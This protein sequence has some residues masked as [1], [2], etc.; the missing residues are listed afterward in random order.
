MSEVVL[1]RATLE[2][3]PGQ[4]A[5]MK[6]AP[7]HVFPVDIEIIRTEDGQVCEID[8]P[9]AI[10]V[11]LIG[12]LRGVCISDFY[13]AIVVE[14]ATIDFRSRNDR[15]PDQEKQGNPAASHCFYVRAGE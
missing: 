15:Y 13:R 14:S 6:N 11:T 2:I 1:G 4:R 10:Q 3:G 5:A 12:N 8:D 9:V 7:V